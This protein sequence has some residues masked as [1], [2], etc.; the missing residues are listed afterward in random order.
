MLSSSYTKDMYV[1]VA[2]RGFLKTTLSL[3][4]I[5]GLLQD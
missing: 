1:N 3:P 2:E 5:I 4:N